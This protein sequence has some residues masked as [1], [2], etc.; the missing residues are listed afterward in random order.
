MGVFGARRRAA[1]VLD[2]EIT[3]TVKHGKK[4]KKDGTSHRDD[5]RFALLKRR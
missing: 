1:G 5:D 4:Y 2:I 3:D